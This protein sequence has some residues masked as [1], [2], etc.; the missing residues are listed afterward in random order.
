MDIRK[1]EAIVVG[2]DH[3]PAYLENKDDFDDNIDPSVPSQ[4]RGTV[5]DKRDMKVIGKTQ[6]LRVR[7]STSSFYHAMAEQL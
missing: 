2:A 7:L 1:D 6:V 4:Y 3:D 5:A